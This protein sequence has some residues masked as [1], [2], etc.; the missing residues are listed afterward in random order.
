[1]K[2]RFSA[3]SK[4]YLA[5]AMAVIVLPVTFYLLPFYF[6]TKIR[7]SANQIETARR[8]L[9]LNDKRLENSRIEEETLAKRSQELA[10]IHNYF[11]SEKE[12]LRII[13]T[14]EGMAKTASVGIEVNVIETKDNFARFRFSV[15]GTYPHVI[16]FVRLL[17]N[18]PIYF[19]VENYWLE[20]LS[21][22][23]IGVED[24]IGTESQ[25]TNPPE[26]RATVTVKTYTA[27]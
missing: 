27:E 6:F 18:A 2:I 25:K 8:G 26:I 17:E 1:M 5:L 14:A 9:F 24:R 19:E 21:P 16:S 7:D 10:A 23:S 22:Q 4:F 13:E 12:P 20:R 11:F 15:V 3:V